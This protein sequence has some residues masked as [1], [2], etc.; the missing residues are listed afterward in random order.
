MPTSCWSPLLERAFRI[1]ATAHQGQFRKGSTLPYFSHPAAVALI[2]MRA[3]FD[4]DAILAAAVLHDTLEDTEVTTD[5]LQAE[6]PPEICAIVEGASER[7][8]DKD[9]RTLPWTQRKE[10]HIERVRRATPEIRAVVLADKLH[11]LHAMTSDHA[12][13][14]G[15]WDRFN[16]SRADVLWYHHEIVSAAC[17]ELDSEIADPRLTMLATECREMLQKLR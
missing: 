10:E 15:V 12:A 4:D 11:N 3:G 16:A 9:G 8:R 13:F 14:E 7:K 5:C 2:L 6:F 1:S 17:S